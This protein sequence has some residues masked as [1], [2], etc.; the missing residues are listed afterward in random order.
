MQVAN[1][2]GKDRVVWTDNGIAP[3]SIDDPET[4]EQDLKCLCM[5]LYY[6]H[7]IILL[8]MDTC[9]S[10]RTSGKLCATLV[11]MTFK[12]Q[13]T[14]YVADTP[15]QM[16]EAANPGTLESA[17]MDLVILSTCDDMVVTVASS[18]GWVAGKAYAATYTQSVALMLCNA[19][20]S[21]I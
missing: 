1:I 10:R 21:F 20:S 3:H 9:E 2:L 11:V 8:C 4:G 16:N 19:I 13:Y 15:A 17:L 5:S 7:Q 18:F 14:V 12:I 6:A